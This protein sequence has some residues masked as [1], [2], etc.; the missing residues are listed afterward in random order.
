MRRNLIAA[1]VAGA[2]ALA[3]CRSEVCTPGS[4]QACTGPGA[5]SGGQACEPNGKSWGPC[6]CGSAGGTAQGGGGGGGGA[7]AGGGA[8]GGD[9]D[10]GSD[11][12]L[13]GRADGGAV[14]CFDDTDCPDPRFFTCNTTTSRCE[15]SCRS[16]N[17]CIAAA[18]G[19]YALEE[20]DGGLGCRCDEARCVVALC[21]ADS[22]CG[23]TLACRSGACIAPPPVAAVASCALTP[24]RAVLKAGAQQK[25]SV[26]AFDATGRPVVLKSGVT[27]TAAAGGTVLGAGNSAT[28]T[29]GNAATASTA[30]VIATIGTLSCSADVETLDGTVA[31]GELG[32]LVTDD[33]SARPVTGATIV[34]SDA[35]GA[36]VGTSATTGGNGYAKLTGITG[37]KVNVTAF[38]ASYDYLT[39][40]NYDLTGSRF[41]SFVVRRH[42]V[43]KHGGQKGTF[44]DVP[45][46]GNLHL[47]FSGMSIAGSLTDL[48]SS[49]LFGYPVTTQ[50]KIG[51]AVDFPDA[52][53]AAGTYLSFA[54]Q[55]IKSSTWA[56][57]L[58][59]VC[60]GAGAQTSIAAGTCGTRS[61]WAIAIDPPLGDVPI[62]VLG[63]GLGNINYGAL[64]PR[65][66]PLFRSGSSSILRDVEFTLANTPVDSN[67][68]PQ[69]ANAGNA[70]YT[71][72]D[73]TFSPP[74]AVR[75]A[76]NFVTRVPD[77][78]RYRNTY[79]DLVTL[80]GAA[81]VAGRG[82]VP[83]GFGAAVNVAPQD[84]KTDKESDLPAPGLV[85]LRMAPS[86]H[87]IESGE[88]GVLLQATSQPA[89]DVNPPATSAL[90]ARLSAN[91]LRFDPTG[92]LPLD[93][94]ASSGQF[95]LLPEGA[96]YNFTSISSAG[97]TGRTF[98]IPGFTT[99][100]ANPVTLVRVAFTDD[101][102]HR[103][104]VLADP[105]DVS[106]TGFTLPQPPAAHVDRTFA[107][108][109]TT[110]G[111]SSMLV[112]TLR[113]SSDPTATPA[114]LLAYRQLVEANSTN[115][116][117]VTDFTVAFASIDYGRPTVQW[118]TP[119]DGGT[120]AHGA[121]A[122]VKVDR[123]RV[124]STAAD[125]GYVKVSFTGGTGCPD[126][127][128]NVDS[129]MGKGE[130]D[131]VIPVTC[132][133]ASISARAR[134]VDVNGADLNPPVSNQI[135]ITVN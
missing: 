16:N 46:S 121:T 74:G 44:T 72:R 51:T 97:I 4:T 25:F 19:I 2:A 87:G 106:A 122:V 81:N 108:G 76:F 58:A 1:V 29:A 21:S 114:T 39:I 89:N 49:L 67:G 70:G 79:F 30:G 6:N 73:H 56:R 126:V 36:T 113:L 129:S 42:Q 14:D 84:A 91:A 103:W 98:R 71:V 124:G 82:V 3:G 105:L 59:G 13:E 90:Y 5:C 48:S 80:M 99:G 10:A 38:S 11:G 66:I 86:H 45:D 23:A 100:A 64:V 115:A 52:G 62:D 9:S 112:Q 28:F 32:V 120:I 65:V 26:L 50:V 78:P 68:V 101:F 53:L 77:L 102:V 104:V 128:G 47:A 127:S 134:L 8:A 18:R 135:T 34:V 119:V 118:Q 109:M 35:T 83:L 117:R 69:I 55:P 85:H 133:G 54:Q 41:L 61:G 7:G 24:D 110:S 131:I 12:G 57:G 15:P 17:D 27:W 22:D 96:R 88:Y 92:V 75:L 93:V 37:T 95:P 20:C 63:S 123:F 130:I 125:D 94:A 60:S 107:L 40:A 31:A 111:R 132:L 33:L 43:D 116:D